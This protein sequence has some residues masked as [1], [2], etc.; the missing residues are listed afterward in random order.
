MY[1]EDFNGS[2]IRMAQQIMQEN[3]ER[4]RRKVAELPEIAAMPELEYFTEAGL[5]VAAME[6]EELVGYLCAYPPREDAFGTTNVRG[7]FVPVHAHG[8]AGHITG[9]ERDRI[10]SGM[11]QAAADKWVRCGIRSHA[12]ALHVNDTFAVKSFFYNGFGL[13]CIDMIRRLEDIPSKRELSPGISGA[14]EYVELLKDEWIRLLQPHNGLIKHL[15]NSPTFM[16]FPFMDGEELY[17]KAGEDA[18]YFAAKHQGR[19]IAYIKLADNGEN[20]ITEGTDMINICGAYCEP[21]YRGSGSY[22]NL[23]CHVMRTVREEG[24]QLL[25]VDCESFNPNARSFWTK[26]FTEYTHSMVRR[27]D[28]KAVEEAID[29]GSCRS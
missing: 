18:R 17:Q 3:Y 13:R 12:I 16:H 7:T 26:Y 23:L 19:L 5:G 25:G 24:Y 8:V 6:G 9:G 2:H 11:Y 27:I 15:G 10:Y 22:H 20:F 28:E 21:E 1:I 4:E 14:M 29:S